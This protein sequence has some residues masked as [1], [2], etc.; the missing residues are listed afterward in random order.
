MTTPAPSERPLHIPEEVAADIERRIQGSGFASVDAF[1]GYVLARLL[2]RPSDV[3]FSE[4]DEQRIRD[5]L[6]SLGYID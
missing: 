2:E 6:R 5:R 4:E 3:P 1:V